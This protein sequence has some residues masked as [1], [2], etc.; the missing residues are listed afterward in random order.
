[1]T[2]RQAYFRETPDGVFIANDP[3]RG[4]WSADHCHAGPVTGLVARAAEAEAGPDKMLTRL[5]LDVVRPVPMTGLRIS[6]EPVRN[7]RTM[8]TSRIEV[9]DLEGTACVSATSM[10][11]SRK[12]Y[13]DMPSAP[14][15]PLQFDQADTARF[16]ISSVLHDKPS[17]RDFVDVAF[18]K[19]QPPGLGPKTMW[20]RAPP[21]LEGEAQSPIQSLCPLADCGN[22]ISANAGTTEIG[23]MNT[24]LTLQIHREP[25]SDWLA[26]EAVSHWYDSGI[27]MSHSVLHDVR[28]PVGIA[29]Q[30]LVLRP[31]A[32]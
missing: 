16:P 3:T 2:L 19:G 7:T 32:G 21:L 26:A 15:T 14:V 1:M 23:F 24:D 29:L 12:A 22:A 17:F 31:A 20:M 10:H 11:L 18:P 25:V 30:T 4:P 5:T 28:G 27:G 6:V 8:A 9:H 13:A